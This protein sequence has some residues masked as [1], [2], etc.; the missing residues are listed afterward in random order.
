MKNYLTLLNKEKGIYNTTG[1]N[2]ID[3]IKPIFTQQ[4]KITK[5]NIQGL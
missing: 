4:K 3:M 2:F 1:E 5:I